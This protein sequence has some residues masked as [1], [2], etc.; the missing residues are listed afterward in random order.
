MVVVTGVKELVKLAP[1]IY[2][3]AQTF[4]KA[5]SKTRAF[6]RYVSRHP[7]ALKYATAGVGVATLTY[8]LM[9]IDYDSLIAQIPKTNRKFKQTRGYLQSSRARQ[10]YKTDYCPKPRSRYGRQKY[11]NRS[12]N[13]FSR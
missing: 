7:R 13:R 12:S 11:F 9:N 6:D 5:G 10:F 4:Y 1:I 2:K 3:V 8:D